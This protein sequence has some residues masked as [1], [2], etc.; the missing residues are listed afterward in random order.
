MHVIACVSAVA[1]AH[2][3]ITRRQERAWKRQCNCQDNNDNIFRPGHHLSFLTLP[4]SGPATSRALLDRSILISLLFCLPQAC[5]HSFVT[6]TTGLPAAA[7]NYTSVTPFSQSNR[8]LLN[9]VQLNAKR[10]S[11]STRPTGVDSHGPSLSSCRHWHPAS[12]QHLPQ[13]AKL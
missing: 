12:L 3:A 8:P 10:Q 1:K 5:P 4:H 6:S 7:D 13:E 2:S 9:A 11:V